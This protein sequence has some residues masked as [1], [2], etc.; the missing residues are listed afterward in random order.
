MSNPL[1]LAVDSDSPA[2]IA[3]I[4]PGD[5]IKSINGQLLND[6]IQYQMLVEE[7]DVELLIDRGGIEY[8]FEITK[9]PGSPLGIEISSAIFD[10]VRT[11]D[12]HCEF[13]FIYQLPPGMRK[14]LYMKD[15]DYRLSFL[16]GNFTTLTRFTEADLERV[17]TERLSPL[18]VSIH[19]TH[20]LLRTELLRNRRGATSLRWLEALL[21]AGIEV[22]GQ[23]VICPGVN[24]GQ[25]FAETLIDILDRFSTLTNV[26]AVPLGVS[27][28]SHESRMRP[29]TPDEAASVVE[30]VEEM[31]K[32]FLATL[33]KRMVYA[34]DEYYIVAG[35]E[36]PEY[37][38]YDDFSQHENGIGITRAFEKSFHGDSDAA[39]GVKSGFFAWVEGAPKEGYRAQRSTN[40][41]A[42]SGVGVPVSI[43]KKP[44]VRRVAILTSTY[45]MATLPGIVTPVFPEVDFIEVENQYF[46]GN[47][48][49]AGLMVGEDIRRS[50]LDS[51]RYDL[52]LLPDVALSEDIFLDGQSLGDMDFPIRVVETNGLA[53]RQTLAEVIGQNRSKAISSS[54]LA[55]QG[56][57]FV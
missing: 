18:F 45:G 10:Q 49:V 9:L 29:H 56:D 25:F 23:L 30:T 22:H 34:S 7:P 19:S 39:F 38:S 28:Y 47:I 40:I 6:I 1:V 50:I 14:T 35:K 24:D 46:G 13:C 44:A 16:Y 20:P 42:T 55:N 32:V 17:I 26:A 57:Q 27:K 33:G 48:G 21:D 3:G 15:D 41:E 51:A 11:C 2:E 8:D 4:L 12:N 53:L 54:V 43:S 36:L 52:Y 5:E 31:Q 37:A